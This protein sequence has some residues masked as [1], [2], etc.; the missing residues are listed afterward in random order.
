MVAQAFNPSPQQ[1][2]ARDICEFEETWPTTASLKLELN[3]SFL[4]SK[5]TFTSI[6]FGDLM[7]MD[8]L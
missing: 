6:K 4:K 3:K 7:D 1:A 8:I 5:N 2:E